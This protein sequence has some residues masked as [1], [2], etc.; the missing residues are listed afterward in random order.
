MEK[1]AARVVGVNVAT[2]PD[3]KEHY[4]NLRAEAWDLMRLWLRDAVLEDSEYWYE[5]A[6]PKYKLRSDGKMILEGKDEMKKR[7]VKS[8]NVADALA[9]AFCRPTEGGVVQILWG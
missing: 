8:P 7:G 9:L 6:H 3:D 2:A 4:A 1:Y 5:L